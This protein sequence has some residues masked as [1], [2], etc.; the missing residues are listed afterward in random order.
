[1]GGLLK[2]KYRGIEMSFSLVSTYHKSYVVFGRSYVTAMHEHDNPYSGHHTIKISPKVPFETQVIFYASGWELC[3]SQDFGHSPRLDTYK[4]SIKTLLKPDWIF[5]DGIDVYNETIQRIADQAIRLKKE[6]KEKFETAK[7]TLINLGVHPDDVE[8]Y[9][10]LTKG[11][12]IHNLNIAKNLVENGR[13]NF[14][15]MITKMEK[16]PNEKPAVIAGMLSLEESGFSKNFN[17]L[18]S[19]LAKASAHKFIENALPDVSFGT[20]YFDEKLR[21]ISL[22]LKENDEHEPSKTEVKN[23]NF[24]GGKVG[25]I[26]RRLN[27]V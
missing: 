13:V 5:V 27:K 2:N 8:R 1:M 21:A 23:E 9:V 10:T 16:Y 15:K 12:V 26:L 18:R 11:R 7:N 25:A 14:P 22:F 19:V 24:G 20:A 4:E 17:H 3:L 6:K